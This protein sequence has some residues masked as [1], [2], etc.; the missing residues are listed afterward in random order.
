MTDEFAA[1]IREIVPEIVALRHELHA[2]PEV[3]FEEQWTSDRIARFFEEAG[4]PYTRGYAKGTGLVAALK[5]AGDKTIALRADMDA[6]EIQENTGRPYTSTIPNRMHA[7]GHDGHMACLCGAA[8]VLAEHL[9]QLNANVKFVFQP[10]EESAGGGR[11]MVSEGV[12]DD[13]DA[14]FALHAW[15]KIPVGHVGL[16]AGAIMAGAGWFRVDV[17]GKGCH[18][19]DPASGVDPVVVAAYITTALQTIT[20]RELDPCKAGIVTIGRIKAGTASNII[21][22]TATLEGTIRA[23]TTETTETIARAIRRLA[24][25][26]ARALRATAEVHFGG[27][28]YPPTINDP[29]MTQFVRD[30]VAETLG[31]DKLVEVANPSMGAEDFAFYLQKVPGAFIWLGNVSGNRES[32]PTL[33][34]PGFDFNDEAIHTALTL[35]T[36]LVA[37]FPG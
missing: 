36:G 5:G 9:D 34:S 12:L 23:L 20:S 32:P 2:H 35:L 4:I 30:T 11:Y 25:H 27:V 7:C 1:T 13:V 37:R 14:V 17:H 3:R 19:A 16:R 10:A 33:H 18:G 31:P 24:D 29:V 26:T 6:L 8:R 21:P 22:D 28:N 15:P